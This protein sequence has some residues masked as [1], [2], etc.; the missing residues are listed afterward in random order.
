MHTPT[1]T[2]T[3]PNTDQELTVCAT[4]QMPC[5]APFDQFARFQEPDDDGDVEII[6]I[7]DEG[8]EEVPL[9]NFTKEQVR[10][11]ERLA[12][13]NAEPIEKTEDWD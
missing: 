6:S 13:E 8:G 5:R 10:E 9:Q 1:F 11:M 7:T 2:Y 12:A 3:D 4:V